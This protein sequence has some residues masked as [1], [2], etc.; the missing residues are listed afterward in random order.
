ME[1][2]L[3]KQKIAITGGLGYIGSELCNYLSGEARYKNIVVIDNRF[4]SERVS[5]LRNWG[6]NFIQGDILDKELMKQVLEDCD[7]VYHLAGKTDVA[8]TATESNEKQ[9]E[10]IRSTGIAGTRMILAHLPET[11]KLVFPSTH[12][13]FEGLKETTFDI[14]EMLAPRTILSYA[15]GK[16]TSENDIRLGQYVNDITPMVSH[17]NHI[18]VRLGSV[19]GYSTDTMRIGIMPNLFSKIASQDGTISLYGGGVQ[20]KSLVNILDV[21]RAMKFLAEGNYTGTYH[22]SNEN[23][24]VKA[25]AE[26]CKKI[27]PKVTLVSTDDEIPNKGYTLSNEK[28][29][30]TGF[31]FLYNLEDSIREMIT[32]WSAQDIPQELEYKILGQKDYIDLRGKISNYELAEP[33]N[34]IGYIESVR[35][36]VRANHYHPIQQQQCLLIK[37]RYVSVTKDL[38]YENSPIE[39]KVI[40]PGDIAVIKPNVAHAMVFLQDSIFLNLV[41]GEREH[42]N[43]GITHT[44]P[45]E[46]VTPSMRE[47]IVAMYKDSC[48]SCGCTELKEAISLGMSPLA[49]NL[50]D[51]KDDYCEMYPLE[52]DY[53]PKCFN[54]QLS[55]VV[56]PG[57]MFDNY[58]YVSS[59]SPVFRKHFEQAASQYIQEF[60]LTADSLVLDIGSNDGVFL[61]PLKEHGIRVVGMEPAK[62]LA[63]KAND[64]GVDTVNDYFN[65]ASAD[66]L[67]HKYGSPDLITA[68]NVFAHADDLAGITHT[69]FSLMKPEGSFIIEV[70][71]L[72][73]TINDLTFDNIY[74]EHTNYW[75]VTSLYN[76]FTLLG[77]CIYK[78]EHIDTHGGSIRCYIS[79]N[80]REGNGSVQKFLE[81]EVTQGINSYSTFK[82]FAAKVQAIRKQVKDNIQ[83]LKDMNLRV[84]GYG[85]PAKATTAL[86]YF[87]ITS[88]DIL[89][90]IEDNKLK[91]GKVIPGTG[92]SIVEPIAGFDVIIVFAWNFLESIKEKASSYQDKGTK[93]ISI[94]D[95]QLPIWE[96]RKLITGKD[97]T[98]K[99][100]L[101]EYSHFYND[102]L[103]D[104][105]PEGSYIKILPYLQDIENGF[106]VEAGAHNGSLSSSSNTKILEDCGWTGTLIEPSMDLY[107]QCEKN[108]PNAIVLRTA[109]TSFDNTTGHVSDQFIN[110]MGQKEDEYPG[111]PF[112]SIADE[113]NLDHIDFFALDVEG[114]EMEV[115]RGI[116]FDKVHITYMLI[117]CNTD[118]YSYEELLQFMIN[119]GYS[120]IANISNFTKENTP[121]WPGTHQDYLFK[122]LS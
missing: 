32:K 68:S 40:R 7:I 91:A 106:F 8:Y 79:K 87:G 104:N 112:Q 31:K 18:I 1:A 100:W 102:Y 97:I 110:V 94:K 54:C 27:N 77:Y 9:D 82:G 13:V 73:D 21:V 34:L 114:Y 25:V 43:Y 37:G 49:N 10:L 35:G 15:T 59:T 26:I 61:K 122:K 58:L 75:C 57:K 120:Y 93:F 17:S 84:C 33:I 99:T 64:S 56:P 80:T 60:G 72:I 39:Y 44:I 119:K 53:C 105:K 103:V 69:V 81:Y 36:S 2:R 88:D 42:E 70:Q 12:V 113:D 47:D 90:T 107:K 22:L 92:I 96:F 67:Y 98:V 29:L 83:V 16:A 38:A 85:S 95:L 30:N 111:V 116:D 24:T 78:V 46:L 121:T 14:E 109:L 6:I 3:K 5:Q 89:S 4:I 48:R 52:M 71:Y 66:A 62:N 86:N 55:I 74:H 117:E 45:Y 19:Y 50:L 51:S 20:Y 63:Q 76:F 115:L 28:L 23:T 41:N 118:K 101:Q 11:C 108:R 65:I